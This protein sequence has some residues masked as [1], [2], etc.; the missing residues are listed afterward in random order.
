[1][2]SIFSETDR[3]IIPRWRSFAATHFS[4][5]LASLERRDDSISSLPN[6]ELEKKKRDWIQ[7]K[8]LDSAIELLTA[9][10]VLGDKEAGRDVA[11]YLLQERPNQADTISSIAEM[12]LNHTGNYELNQVKRVYWL[13]D[14]AN[15]RKIAK[16]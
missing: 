2:G 12:V 8:N 4:S 3:K 5:E 10:L 16:K 13:K 1:M 11:E 6:E 7:H 15:T 14:I 9:S